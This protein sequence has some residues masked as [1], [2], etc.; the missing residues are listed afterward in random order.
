VAT[1]RG[2]GLACCRGEAMTSFMMS[3]WSVELEPEVEEW[4]ASLG[5]RQFAIAAAR[6]DHLA[7]V[8]SRIQMPRSR[9]LGAG[10]FELRFDMDRA[11]MR[12][13]F[14]FPGDRRVVLL[15][16]FRKQ[17]Q[18]ERSEVERARRAMAM[19]VERR[20]TAEEEV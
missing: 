13:T 1:V 4:L 12:I 14:F 9:T 17:R 6:I 5:A 2:C 16:V 11:A 8:G 20:H 18:N 10:L 3:S 15:S 19:C 7:E